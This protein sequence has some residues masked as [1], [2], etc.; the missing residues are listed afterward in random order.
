MPGIEQ[1]PISV[2]RLKMP[3]PLFA[4]GIFNDDLVYSYSFLVGTWI[5]FVRGQILANHRLIVLWVI[6][7]E[8]QNWRSMSSALASISKPVRPIEI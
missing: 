6:G 8:F 3:F 2:Q 5:L 7:H 1:S 4:L